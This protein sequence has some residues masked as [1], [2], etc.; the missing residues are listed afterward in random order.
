MPS[1]R[2]APLPVELFRDGRERLRRRLPEK[3]IAILV[4]ADEMPRSADQTYPY[5]PNPDLFRL[6]G[7]DQEET[8]LVICP[9]AHQI[10]HRE[11]LFIRESNPEIAIWEGHK[12]TKEEARAISGIDTVYWTSEFEQVCHELIIRSEFIFLALNENIRARTQVPGAEQRF[13]WRIREKYPLHQYGRLGPIM[14]EIRA[15]KH[16]AEVDVIRKACQIT[17]QAFERVLRFVRPGVREYEVEA[18]IIH[19]FIRLGAQGHAYQPIIAS[20]PNACVLHYNANSAVCEDGHLLLLDFG[21]EYAHYASDLSRTIPVNGRFTPRQKA[22]YEAVM[23][24]MNHAKSLLRPG[25]LYS[26]Y[27]KEVGA[28]MTEELIGLGLLQK[29]EVARQDPQKPLYKK[30]F[31]HGTSH[32]LGLDVHDSGNRDFPMAAGMIFTCEPGIYIPEEGLGI[33]LENDILLTDHGPVDLMAHIPLL[34]DDIEKA[35][36]GKV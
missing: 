15:I 33:R 26:E 23:R 6:C 22:V 3:A 32:F 18:E 34:P 8:I 5:R 25:T 21:A 16:P 31:M 1:A 10:H 30:Y 2:Y 28:C 20:G 35:M 9:E 13:A 27:E 24:V 12:L 17:G 7:I 36:Q 14:D 4:S 29:E 11:I 19:E